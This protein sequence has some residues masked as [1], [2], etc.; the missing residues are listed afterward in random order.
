MV[1]FAHIILAD[2]ETGTAMTRGRTFLTTAAEPEP[3][4]DVRDDMVV[5]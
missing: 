1:L 2:S 4:L 5:R 3:L